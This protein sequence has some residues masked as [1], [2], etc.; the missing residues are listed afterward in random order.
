MSREWSYW[1]RNKLQ[2]LA[3]YLPRFNSASQ[4]SEQRIYLDLMA[5]EPDNVEKHT[6]EKFDGSPTVALKSD[7]GFTTLRFGELGA[8]ADKLSAALAERF[9][10]DNRYR[11]VK[12]DC[13]ETIDEVLR[14]LQPL[15]WAP[16]FAFLDQQGAEIH[17]D[18]IEKLA[19]F[20]RN[21]NNWKT[22]LWI[23]MSPAMIARGVRGTNAEE[24]ERQ[25][26]LLY[27]GDD[28]LRIKRAL[29]SRA[30]TAGQYRQ[31]MVNLMRYRLET[32]LGYQFTHRIP[33]T[34]STN[35]MTIFDMVF[36]T[37][38]YVGDRIMQHLYNQAAQR[39]PEMMRQARAAKE[40]K[41]AEKAGVVGLFDT[42]DL[43]VKPDAKLGQVLWQ[44]EPTWDPASR[45][46]WYADEDSGYH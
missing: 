5:G 41:E 3:D 33:M 4:R 43:T 1:T 21:K 13:N 15:N 31:E 32:D 29:H 23:L 9:P 6:G 26:S 34:M 44:P 8:K 27:G 40:E 30:I 35:K 38:H 18:T 24:F 10:G 19:R 36:A 39:E 12:G 14:E 16:T 22:E 11:V 46:W 37:D 28:W 17:W 42:R 25:V 45:D 20:R 7:P 2:I